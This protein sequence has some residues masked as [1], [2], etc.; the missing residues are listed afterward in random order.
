MVGMYVGLVVAYGFIGFSAE[1]LTSGAVQQSLFGIVAASNLLHFYYD[2]FIWKVREPETSAALGVDNAASAIQL[3]R[4]SAHAL[5]WLVLTAVVGVCFL[6][7]RSQK[8]SKLEQAE[9]IVKQVPL[10]AEAHNTL[11]RALVDERRYVEAIRV[12]RTAEK[13]DASRYQTHLYLGIALTAIGQPETG[14]AE[15]QRSVELNSRDSFLHFHLAMGYISRGQPANA[16]VHLQ[17]SVAMQPD[18]PVGQ[19]N[20]GV[21]YLH[22]NQ[23]KNAINSL[24]KVLEISPE[25]PAANL[26]LGDA[27]LRLGNTDEAICYLQKSRQV[28]ALNSACHLSLATALRQ[29]GQIQAANDSLATAIQ[30]RLTTGV[31]DQSAV[32]V[33]NMADRLL[34][35][36]KRRDLDALELAARCYAAAYRRKEAATAASLGAKLAR[37]QGDFQLADSLDQFAERYIKEEDDHL[38]H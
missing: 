20:L 30:L 10:S 4:W 32:K 3:P 16:L 2:G 11:A 35:H 14:F 27:H 24:R 7:E 31:D 15:L 8:M 17:T 22:L 23:P 18:D 6:S 26:S 33:A 29:S 38:S 21:L 37:E 19:Y 34:E 5:K 36:T 13:L 25:Y 9:A 12:S 1:R 28:D